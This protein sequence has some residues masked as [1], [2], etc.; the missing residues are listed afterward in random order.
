MCQENNLTDLNVNNLVYLSNLH[1]HNNNLTQLDLHTNV[2]IDFMQCGNN[3]ID[4]LD[5]S[6]ND[7]WNVVNLIEMPSLTKVCVSELPVSYTI[8]TSGSPNI[9]LE[10]CSFIGFHDI[11]QHTPNIFPNP[12][13]GKLT[14]ENTTSYN[15]IVSF[16]NINGKL[17]FKTNLNTG[18]QIIDISNFPKGIYTLKILSDKNIT[19]RKIV[20]K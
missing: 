3:L 1:C 12:T 9:T 15:S 20:K 17:I 18:I 19:V 6:H 13:T 10:I 4:S 7:S 5:L 14:I 16:Y 8:L 11:D 2:S